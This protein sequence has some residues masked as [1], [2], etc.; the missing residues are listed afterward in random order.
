MNFSELDNLG[1]PLFALHHQREMNRA[2]H[3]QLLCIRAM[4]PRCYHQDVKDILRA[5]GL[6]F[7][8]KLK[9]QVCITYDG[10]AMMRCLRFHKLV[11]CMCQGLY[12]RPDQDL[13]ISCRHPRQH[14]LHEIHLDSGDVR[15]TY[16]RIM[17]FML[18]P[19]NDREGKIHIIYPMDEELPLASAPLQVPVPPRRS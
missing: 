18:F 19:G 16:S 14:G 15:T 7:S 10:P 13:F 9:R 11:L 5:A 6:A 4:Y 3:P 8:T 12:G 2:I 1:G 17:A